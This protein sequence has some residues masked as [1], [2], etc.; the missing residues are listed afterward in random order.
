MFYNVL[1]ANKRVE[2]FV[3][4]KQ[5]RHKFVDRGLV[6]LSQH[7]L[8][9]YNLEL[10]DRAHFGKLIHDKQIDRGSN[11]PIIWTSATTPRTGCMVDCNGAAGLHWAD[12][13]FRQ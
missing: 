6:A 9:R 5:W 1:S 10:S 12:V 2:S 11:I 13:L 4:E 3:S 7:C 8:Y